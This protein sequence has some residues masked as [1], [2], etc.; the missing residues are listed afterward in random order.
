MELFLCSTR[1]DWQNRFL[2][3]ENSFS[4][5]LASYWLLT[6]YATSFS[7]ENKQPSLEWRCVHLLGEIIAESRRWV[8]NIKISVLLKKGWFSDVRVSLKRE[9]WHIHMAQLSLQFLQRCNV[10]YNRL[11]D[12]NKNTFAGKKF[13]L[14]FG[15]ITFATISHDRFFLWIFVPL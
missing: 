4:E 6:L 3:P 7:G 11:C 14:I 15:P 8:S 12:Y 9:E 10:D 13:S 2:F 1:F 5:E